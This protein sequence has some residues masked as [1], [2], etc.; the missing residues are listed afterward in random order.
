MVWSWRRLQCHGYWPSWTK[1][2]RFV[3]LLQQEV[4]IEDS[5]NACWSISKSTC[6]LLSNKVPK[7]VI[8]MFYLLHIIVQL[9]RVEYMHSRA[10]LHRDIKP[11]NF[12]MGLGRKANQVCYFVEDSFFQIFPP[13]FPFSFLF[14]PFNYFGGFWLLFCC[15][16]Y[17]WRGITF[18]DSHTVSTYFGI[19]I[20]QDC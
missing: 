20:V 5:V 18:G 8:L 13:A 12:L 16:S 19:Q 14:P 10:F 9:N 6:Q 11:D 4:Y 1:S 15:F 2:G 7:I 3:Q 17:E